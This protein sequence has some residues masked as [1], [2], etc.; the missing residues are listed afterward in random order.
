MDEA[1]L[2]DYEGVQDTRRE[3]GISMKYQN[4]FFAFL[5]A[6]LTSSALASGLNHNEQTPHA[7]SSELSLKLVALMES[8]ESSSDQAWHFSTL[9]CIV[10]PA[11]SEEGESSK[12]PI[13]Q[14]LV[15]GLNAIGKKA[16]LHYCSAKL[17]AGGEL[18]IPEALSLEL[19]ENF[20][21][22]EIAPF[23]VPDNEIRMYTTKDLRCA[24]SG[25]G[26][27]VS[28]KCSLSREIAVPFGGS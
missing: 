9:S 2:N 16:M 1:K 7:L 24:R 22:L 26:E 4:T 11:P 25:E 27:E 13:Q 28:A 5:I 19:V 14:P 6:H 20:D 12:T 3:Q 17:P 15:K 10:M 23:S 18:V 21:A 8:D